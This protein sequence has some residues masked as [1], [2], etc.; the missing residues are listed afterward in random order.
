[1]PPSAR[2][3]RNG[4]AIDE[5]IQA[6]LDQ[7]AGACSR[8]QL[9]AVTSRSALD[10]EIRRGRLRR[11]FPGAYARPWDVDDIATREVAALASTGGHGTISHRSALR[12]W[13]LP[14]GC[15]DVVHVTTPSAVRR[16]GLR[17]GLVVHRTKLPIATV[18]LDCARTTTVAA[19]V[20]A[21]WP[22]MPATRR[23]EPAIAAIRESMVRVDE[24]AAVLRLSTRLP[25]HAELVRLIELL[26]AGCESELEIWGYLEVF[27]APGLRHAT[28][29]RSIRLNGHR[30]RLDMSYDDERVAVELDGRRYHSTWEQRERDMR[31][32]LELAS[33]GWL[34]IRLSH[35]Q[36]TRDIEGV[37][38]SIRSVLRDRSR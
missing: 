12:R 3:I 6:A 1:M 30:Y 8:R 37:R 33:A 4:A 21:S 38:D 13:G 20:V 27:D 17:P 16:R 28:R 10:E 19:A 23:R 25:A 5:R 2:S 11:V 26:R 29:Q 35:A 31:R 9:L 34:T 14:G 24:L 15:S 18:Q 7:S 36:L 22:T 32:D